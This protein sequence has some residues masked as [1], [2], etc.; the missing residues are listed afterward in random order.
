MPGGNRYSVQPK[1]GGLSAIA[2]TAAYGTGNCQFTS[3]VSGATQV[4]LYVTYTL[5]ATETN[6][7]VDI[8]LESGPSA[9]DLHRLTSIDVT[10]GSITV[11]P[12]E[13][14]FVGA[15]TTAPY[16]FAIPLEV[17]DDYIKVSFKETNKATNF[18]TIT[19]YLKASS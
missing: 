9:T 16:K 2:L 5:G 7:T 3:S 11:S 6:N 18:G 10:S 15:D 14:H 13:H 12:T 1:V 4:V 17:A 19:A 8:K